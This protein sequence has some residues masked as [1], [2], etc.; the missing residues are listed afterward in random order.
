MM[1]LNYFVSLTIQTVTTKKYFFYIQTGKCELVLY[2]IFNLI[3]LYM[4]VSFHS[5]RNT[6]IPGVNQQLSISN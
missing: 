1:K 4:A 2:A 5:W 6:L 3:W